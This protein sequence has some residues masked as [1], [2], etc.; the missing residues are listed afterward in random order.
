MKNKKRIIVKRVFILVIAV[1]LV[2]LLY[3]NHNYKLYKKGKESV[4]DKFPN[5]DPYEVKQ[6]KKKMYKDN[7]QIKIGDYTIA[8][9][10]VTY[11]REKCSGW[12]KFAVTADG[13]AMEYETGRKDL[14]IH[15]NP[16]GARR[17][18]FIDSAIDAVGT[19]TGTS[20]SW[21]KVEGDVMYVYYYIYIDG[22]SIF[23]HCIYLYDVIT[24]KG[25]RDVFEEQLKENMSGIFELRENIDAKT[26][27]FSTKDNDYEVVISPYTCSIRG[28]G[29][30]QITDLK[31]HFKNG[32]TLNVKEND[33]VS[34]DINEFGEY[35]PDEEGYLKTYSCILGFTKYTYIEEI[36]YVEVN[37]EKLKE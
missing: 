15:R 3:F 28:D 23:N 6:A 14:K 19:C 17:N 18:F 7:Q 29:N 20:K 35:I 32:D 24:G 16:F 12:C 5:L 27:T 10:E 33:I 26:Y 34:E 1:I 4:F 8:L 36:D 9:E 2:T 37:G 30:P 25:T 21:Y 22:S 31:I 11:S 13:N